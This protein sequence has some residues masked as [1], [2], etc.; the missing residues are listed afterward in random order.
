MHALESLVLSCDMPQGTVTLGHL[1][2]LH[3]TSFLRCKRLGLT[4]SDDVE[5]FRIYDVRNSKFVEP[6]PQEAERLPILFVWADSIDIKVMTRFEILKRQIEARVQS[7]G[8][9]GRKAQTH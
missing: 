4:L 1:K 3:D 2:T 5:G 7:R 8:G 6:L 9:V